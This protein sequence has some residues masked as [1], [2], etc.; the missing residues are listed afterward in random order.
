MYGCCAVG[1]QL[2]YGWC[3]V[4]VRLEIAGKCLTQ[5]KLKLLYIESKNILFAFAS[6]KNHLSFYF[7]TCYFWEG[8]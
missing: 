1:A 4:G 8:N 2:V 7:S 6:S 5:T 3:T